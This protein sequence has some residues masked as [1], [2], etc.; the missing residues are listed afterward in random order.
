MI[1]HLFKIFHK[2]CLPNVAYDNVEGDDNIGKHTTYK[3]CSKDLN[4]GYDSNL[5]E[6]NLEGDG[7]K[8]SY[9]KLWDVWM[10]RNKKNLV[11]INVVAKNL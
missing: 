2:Y 1:E 6:H 11:P 8:C 3:T 4:S 9:E 10:A 7:S 5:N